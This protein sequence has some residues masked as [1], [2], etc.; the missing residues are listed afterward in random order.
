[1]TPVPVPVIQ[2]NKT[3]DLINWA[4]DLESALNESNSK[5]TAI[6]DWS[7]NQPEGE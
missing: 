4:L 2:G 1:M 7:E 6:K 5:I 3:G